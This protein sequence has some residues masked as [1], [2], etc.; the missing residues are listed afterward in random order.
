MPHAF[1]FILCIHL[2]KSPNETL[3]K[4]RPIQETGG[5]WTNLLF[6]IFKE[7]QSDF[8]LPVEAVG[9]SSRLPTGANSDV[10][11]PGF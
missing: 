1:R 3:G 5:D 2:R 4:G 11:E 9:D 6:V 10:R 8:L 7:G